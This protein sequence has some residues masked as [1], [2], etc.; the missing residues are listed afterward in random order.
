MKLDSADNGNVFPSLHVQLEVGMTEDSY[1]YASPLFAMESKLDE[2]QFIVLPDFV[3]GKYFKI[4]YFGKVNTH[5]ADDK[6]YT[7]IQYVGVAGSIISDE[8]LK[9]FFTSQADLM[10]AI[11]YADYPELDP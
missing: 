4:N 8:A 7:S 11:K 1:H 6:Y 2:Q 5:S 3:F 10:D 9:E